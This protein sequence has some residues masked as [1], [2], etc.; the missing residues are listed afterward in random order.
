MNTDP[1]RTE[2]GEKKAHPHG[3]NGLF[4]MPTLNPLPPSGPLTLTKA[5]LRA[6]LVG[7][8]P[9]LREKRFC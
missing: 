3:R 1:N 5:L 4:L 9:A 6:G 2:Y 7:P 8:V